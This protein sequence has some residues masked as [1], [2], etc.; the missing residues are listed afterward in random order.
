MPKAV[1]HELESLTFDTQWHHRRIAGAKTGR[2]P[3]DK[4][5]VVHPESEGNIWWGSHSPNKPLSAESYEKNRSIALS[6]LE[7]SPTLFVQDGLVNW[8]NEV[9]L[10]QHDRLYTTA[11]SGEHGLATQKEAVEL[12]AA[13]VPIGCRIPVQRSIH[14]YAGEAQGSS[15]LLPGLP[16]TLYAEFD[17]PSL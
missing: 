13:H 6:F 14:G 2:S 10:I 17:D 7:Q 3:D 4:R 11:Q 15:C 9:C 12:K 1:W 16:R 5:V 8:G